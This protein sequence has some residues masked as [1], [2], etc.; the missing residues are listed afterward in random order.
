[1]FSNKYIFLYTSALVVA[2]AVVLALT[3]SLLQPMQELN[4]K[5]A[6]M[7]EILKA[8]GKTV[9]GEEAVSAYD[10]EIT[11]EWMVDMQG[12]IVS[13]YKNEKGEWKAVQGGERALRAFD[14]DLKAQLNKAAAGDADALFPIFVCRGNRYIVPLQG[15]GLWGPIWGYLAL[16]DDFNTVSGATFG[17]KGETPGLGAEIAEDAFQQAFKG[18]KLFDGQGVF[19]S[20]TVQKG[21]AEKYAGGVE[22]AV[23]AISGGTMTSNGVTAMLADCLEYYR[24]FF[25]HMN[26]QREA[27]ADTTAAGEVVM[28]Q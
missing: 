23:D 6:K 3:A 28:L 26:Q 5:T 9:T 24:P 20:I 22:H 2:V 7:Q 11:S 4:R 17:H 18:K 10:R 8:A 1:M 15:K 12:R 14:C 21:G 13:E 25:Q 27:V 16:D 19:T